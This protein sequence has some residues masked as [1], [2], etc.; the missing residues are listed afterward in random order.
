MGSP[1]SWCISWTKASSAGGEAFQTYTSRMS[2][3]PAHGPQLA[4]GLVPRAD[5]AHDL[6]VLPGQV[7]GGDGPCGAGAAAGDPGAV[8]DAPQCAGGCIK[9]QH[10]VDTPGQS[11]TGIGVVS[12]GGGLDGHKAASHVDARLDVHAAVTLGRM[13]CHKGRLG[14]LAAVERAVGVL[15][16]C[17]HPVQVDEAAHFVFVQQ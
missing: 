3:H 7:L 8:H 4:A 10:R 13:Q 1:V 9:Q 11:Q 14:Y 12:A 5:D 6:G 16:G 2:R 17:L 15:H